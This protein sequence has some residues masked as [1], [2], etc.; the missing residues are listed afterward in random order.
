MCFGDRGLGGNKQG[1]RE[2]TGGTLKKVKLA[3]MSEYESWWRV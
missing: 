2:V 3:L 1:R